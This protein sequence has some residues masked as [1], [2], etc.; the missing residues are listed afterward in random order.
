MKA[1]TER[2]MSAMRLSCVV[3][4]ASAIVCLAP[5][6]SIASIIVYGPQAA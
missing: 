6:S 1:L 5:V 2:G 3:T 4:L